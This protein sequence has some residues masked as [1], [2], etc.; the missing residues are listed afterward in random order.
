M[1]NTG[2]ITIVDNSDQTRLV[3]WAGMNNASGT[4][5]PLA[6]GPYQSA[7]LTIEGTFGSGTWILQGSN[8]G[9]TTWFALKDWQNTAISATSS[10]LFILASALPLL[11]QLSWSGATSP[12]VTAYLGFA[13]NYF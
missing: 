2:T 9:G 6:I 4:S 1:A 8:D 11:I 3:T 13:K 5:I 7:T 12:S 10:A